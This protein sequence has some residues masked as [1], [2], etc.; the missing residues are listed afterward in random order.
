MGC[1][2]CGLAVFLVGLRLSLVFRLYGLLLVV[3]CWLVRLLPTVWLF[4][5]RCLI[6]RLAAMFV[7]CL[8]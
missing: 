5:I 7:V 4:A 8:G 3:G 1:L 2:G 6:C